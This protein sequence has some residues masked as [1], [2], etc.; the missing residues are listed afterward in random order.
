[1]IKLYD[2]QLDIVER[3]KGKKSHALFMG[4][5]SGKTVTSL[6]IMSQKP[7][8]KLLIVCLV[9]KRNEWKKDA[10]SQLGLNLTILDQGTKKNHELLLDDSDGYV[11]NFESAWRLG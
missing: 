8:T 9:S 10:Q 1:M 5:G 11:I 2:Y 6:T 4:L 3:E 7:T